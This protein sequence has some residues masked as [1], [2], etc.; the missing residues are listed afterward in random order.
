MPRGVRLVDFGGPLTNW[1]PVRVARRYLKRLKLEGL[2]LGL[3]YKQIQKHSETTIHTLN[4]P[5]S[6]RTVMD[7]CEGPRHGVTE[8]EIYP[9]AAF[10]FLKRPK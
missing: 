6:F 7:W 8:I 10:Y 3:A 9:D 4:D 5:V 1:G 2:A